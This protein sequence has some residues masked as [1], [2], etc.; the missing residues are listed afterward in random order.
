MDQKQ[1]NYKKMEELAEYVGDLK[2]ASMFWDMFM[3]LSIAKQKKYIKMAKQIVSEE[4]GIP[5]DEL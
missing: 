4:C 3:D 5:V 1:K 2:L